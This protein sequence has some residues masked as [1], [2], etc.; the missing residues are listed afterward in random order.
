MSF[1]L[2]RKTDRGTL[3]DLSAKN[4]GLD[5]NFLGGSE[6]N[7]KQHQEKYTHFANDTSVRATFEGKRN[8]FTVTVPEQG[9]LLTGASLVIT[10]LNNVEN[11]YSDC[12][13][14]NNFIKSV[15]VRSNGQCIQRLEKEKL[16]V[17][18]TGLNDKSTHQQRE[19]FRDFTN[20]DNGPFYLPLNLF[21]SKKGNGYP[22]IN[23]QYPLE[24]RVEMI[25]IEEAAI[26]L[27]GPRK[28]D[29]VEQ[30]KID[31]ADTYNCVVDFSDGHSGSGDHVHFP[32][33]NH[34]D[35]DHD[36][37]LP[38]IQYFHDTDVHETEDE[39]NARKTYLNSWVEQT[40]LTLLTTQK[41]L[42]EEERASLASS[43]REMLILQRN[44]QDVALPKNDSTMR[45][46]LD[47]NL[48]LRSL[49]FL[50][51]RLQNSSI[52][53][54][55]ING[56][57]RFEHYGKFLKS[58]HLLQGHDNPTAGFVGGGTLPAGYYIYHFGEPSADGVYGRSNLTQLD[59]PTIEI[60]DLAADDG[61]NQLKLTMESYNLLI[62]KGGKSYL[63]L[64][65]SR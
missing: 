28:T 38:Q 64:H 55:F 27:A 57:V 5:N 44:Y 56:H 36:H 34:G 49:T 19:A 8:V 65:K 4:E 1:D 61:T 25:P 52:V 18:F 13:W 21:F 20:T 22:L 15:E 14:T 60:R 37:E 10:S 42:T 35:G 30:T 46:K 54:Y 41:I 50:S 51:D 32:P 31:F 58:Y 12:C 48:P 23:S 43:T 7:L 53:R 17:P 33:G 3:T 2:C 47:S 26:H 24:I 59:A 16:H 62:W 39:Y 6:T 45:V 29:E 11:M 40:T 63:V 9:D